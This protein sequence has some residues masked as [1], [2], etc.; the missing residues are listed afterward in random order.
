MDWGFTGGE[1]PKTYQID[2]PGKVKTKTIN[3]SKIYSNGNNNND[4]IIKEDY[5]NGYNTVVMIITMMITDNINNDNHRN[6][7]NTCNKSTQGA[8]TSAKETKFPLS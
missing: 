4:N 6:Y 2:S 8:H 5:N 7:D 1:I 3:K